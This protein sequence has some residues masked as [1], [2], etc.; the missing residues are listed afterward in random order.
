MFLLSIYIIIQ[1]E[2]KGKARNPGVLKAELLSPWYDIF[3][4]RT[5]Q[6]ER[7]NL[8][9]FSMQTIKHYIIHTCVNALISMLRQTDYFTCNLMCYRILFLICEIYAIFEGNLFLNFF[10]VIK[11]KTYWNMAM[12]I[13]LNKAT[14]SYTLI[15]LDVYFTEFHMPV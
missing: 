11:T 8:Q 13:L 9:R 1:M 4:R 15:P 7:H 10:S 3:K 12:S 5:F 2:Q 14:E 6:K